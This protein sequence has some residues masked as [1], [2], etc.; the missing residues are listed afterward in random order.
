[1]NTY[2]FSHPYPAAVAYQFGQ[3]WPSNPWEEILT[4]NA[5]QTTHDDRRPR[6][7]NFGKPTNMCPH[8]LQK[9]LCIEDDTIRYDNI[10]NWADIYIASVGVH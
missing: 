5:R 9:S 3:G 2:N 8:E 4:E 6:I 1:M 7:E 10:N